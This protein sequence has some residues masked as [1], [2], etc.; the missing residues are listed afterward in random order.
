MSLVVYVHGMSLVVV[1]HGMGLVLA[2]CGG[3]ALVAA[4][5]HTA[6][7]RPWSPRSRRARRR[8]PGPL[9]ATAPDLA[10]SK[11]DTRQ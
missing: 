4:L 6:R 1:V 3:A 9:G 2:V 7:T 10:T 11:A 8:R 5:P